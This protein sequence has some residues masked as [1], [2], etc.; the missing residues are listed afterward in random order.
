MS[1]LE[2]IFSESPSFVERR[3]IYTYGLAAT[4]SL[5]KAIFELEPANRLGI[6]PTISLT[7][8]V[9]S[10]HFRIYQFL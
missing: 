2:K 8:S 1:P 6:G 5:T 9:S 3:E 4:P 7:D 10:N